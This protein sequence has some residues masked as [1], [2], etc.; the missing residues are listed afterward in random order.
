MKDY[1]ISESFTLPSK[2]LIYDKKFDPIITLHSMQTRHEMMRLSPGEYPY[3]SLC[4]IIDDCI[5]SDID[6][7]MINLCEISKENHPLN[8]NVYEFMHLCKLN[9][10][11]NKVDDVDNILIFWSSIVLQL[12]NLDLSKIICMK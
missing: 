7:K 3:K 10:F 5:V 4:D 12:F 2:G 11:I 8:G 1:T 6:T 9:Q